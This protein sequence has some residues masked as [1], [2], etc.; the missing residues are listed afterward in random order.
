MDAWSSGTRPLTDE[1]S[2]FTSVARNRL[3]YAV[4]SQTFRSADAEPNRQEVGD[5]P[6][7]S[8]SSRTPLLAKE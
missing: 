2:F 8:H 6:T 5:V 4:V 3:L 1:P 7:P